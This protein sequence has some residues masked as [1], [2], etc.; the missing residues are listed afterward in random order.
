ML[1]RAKENFIKK[2]KELHGENYHYENI[3]YKDFYTPISILCKKHGTFI[4]T[5]RS[6]LRGNGCTKCQTK[7][8]DL[9]FSKAIEKFQNKYKYEIFTD[10]EF[11]PNKKIKITCPTH[12][13]FY[14]TTYN[15]IRGNGC[16]RCSYD[17]ESEKVCLG[18]YEFTKRCNAIHKNKYSYKKVEY[19]NNR[20]KVE[21]ICPIHGSFFQ[22]PHDHLNGCGCPKCK[23]VKI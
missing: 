22:N 3:D 21:I 4:I 6:H 2:A 13:D 23:R 5:P 10:H 19:K 18:Y 12:G 20:S 8:F 15:H 16:P 11:N 9:F 7:K 17:L 1:N 14:Q